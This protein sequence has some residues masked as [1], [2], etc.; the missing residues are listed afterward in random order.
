MVDKLV[1]GGTW[2]D[3]LEE[4]VAVR[5]AGRLVLV[6]HMVAYIE[7]S[8][9]DFLLIDI[10]PFVGKVLLPRALYSSIGLII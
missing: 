7:G 2:R 6:V 5:L 9:M 8:D 3:R 4:V 10:I 1:A